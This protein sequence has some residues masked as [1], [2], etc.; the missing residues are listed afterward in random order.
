MQQLQSAI[1][2]NMIKQLGGMGNI[3]E[4]VK[5]LQEGGSEGGSNPMMDMMKN[6][7]GDK[8]PNMQNMGGMM[9]MAQKMMA[10]GG[11]GNM[12]KAPPGM[13]KGVMKIRR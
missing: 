5:G 12:M 7:M 11:M 13:P 8:M 6:M 3:M 2:P 1:D 4:M 9:E 10:G